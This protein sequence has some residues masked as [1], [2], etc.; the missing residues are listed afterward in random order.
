MDMTAQPICEHLV[1]VP[2]RNGFA[3]FLTM[4]SALT[5]LS[6]TL[7]LFLDSPVF[8]S[9]SGS[10]QK[11]DLL[12]EQRSVINPVAWPADFRLF[13]WKQFPEAPS[14]ISTILFSD[15]RKH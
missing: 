6:L 10:L 11:Y 3:H 13:K 12:L 4:P 15:F 14:W 1:L 8:F 9:K 7:Q 5:P 2:G